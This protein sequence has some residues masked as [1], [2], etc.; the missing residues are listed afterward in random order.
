VEINMKFA[1][2]NLAVAAAFVAAGAAA[3]AA[4]L[5]LAV[6]GSVHDQGWTVSGLTGSGTLNFSSSLIGALN[7]ATVFVEV[8]EPAVPNI[9][10]DLAENGYV[11]I[12]VGAPIQ[13]LTGSFDGSTVSVSKVST[14]GGARQT[15][16]DDAFSSSG[17]FIEITNIT[18][19]LNTKT[20]YADLFGDHGVDSKGVALWTIDTITGATSFAAV[21][22]VT[23]SV[24]T[25]SGLRITAEG[26]ENLRT[27]LG[28]ME[29]GITIL[30]NITDYGTIESTIS[31]T[32]VK[33]VTPTVPEPS[34]YALMGMGLVA[35]GLVSRRRAK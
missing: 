14:T 30:Q 24:N 18:V 27:G 22:G 7:A 12:G 8:M 25:L 10:G 13:S 26:F 6:G 32:A 9:V 23:T 31:V 35:M 2:K 33:D 1:M 19:D 15:S 34:T 21:E 11:S 17:G 5:T 16:F 29:G 20:V 4:D 3:N 28:I